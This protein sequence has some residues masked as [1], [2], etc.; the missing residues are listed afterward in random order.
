MQMHGPDLHDSD[1]FGCNSVPYFPILTASYQ[2]SNVAHS[3]FDA[4]FSFN[5]S[6][7]SINNYR[8]FSCFLQ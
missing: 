6:S 5:V 2:M 4:V 8:Q 1:F 3:E 7:L